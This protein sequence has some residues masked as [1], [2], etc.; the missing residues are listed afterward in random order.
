MGW[1]LTPLFGK[2]L[3]SDKKAAGTNIRIRNGVNAKRLFLKPAKDLG[4]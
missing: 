4:R 3:H 2:A 1:G